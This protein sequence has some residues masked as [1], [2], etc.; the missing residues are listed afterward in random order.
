MFVRE[1]PAVAFTHQYPGNVFTEAQ[2]PSEKRSWILRVFFEYLGRRVLEWAFINEDVSG[3][4]ILF[5]NHH[6]GNFEEWEKGA[7]MQGQENYLYGLLQAKDGY[8]RRNIV[9][10]QVEVRDEVDGSEEERR[11]FWEHCEGV[12]KIKVDE[13]E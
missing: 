7:D 11:R 10:D 8:N 3:V 13:I 5:P 9:A 6:Q 2:V 4:R 1:H 12:M